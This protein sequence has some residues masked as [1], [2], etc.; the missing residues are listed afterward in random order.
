MAFNINSFISSMSGDGVRPNLFEI[1]FPAIDGGNGMITHAFNMRATATALPSSTI[2]V[3]RAN[4]FGRTAKFAGNRVFDDWDVTVLLDESDFASSASGGVKSSLESWSNS[5]NLH[6]TNARS[7]G[8]TDPSSYMRD[9]F[10]NLYSKEGLVIAQYKMIGCF[11]TTVGGTNLS[12]A[13]NDTIASFPVRFSMQWWERTDI[14][15]MNPV[16]TTTQSKTLG[17]NPG[18]TITVVQ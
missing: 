3:A 10:I 8:K 9:A 5:L 14:N 7:S 17:T 12:W 11:P 6:V 16:E 15:G 2:G 4:Y 13:D 1:Y 18:T